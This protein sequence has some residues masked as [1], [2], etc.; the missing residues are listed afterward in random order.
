VS[1]PGRERDEQERDSGARGGKV[2]S[3]KKDNEQAVRVVANQES[4]FVVA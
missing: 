2:L 4:V 1:T 3:L